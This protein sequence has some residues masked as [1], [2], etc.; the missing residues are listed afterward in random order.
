VLEHVIRGVL[1]EVIAIDAIPALSIAAV[2]ILRALLPLSRVPFK[3]EVIVTAGGLGVL[4]E[5]LEDWADV[6]LAAS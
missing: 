1:P 5:M 2:A 3:G 4:T 6:L